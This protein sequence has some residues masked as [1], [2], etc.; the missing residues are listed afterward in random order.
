MQKDGETQMTNLTIA[1]R[2]FADA[3]KNY[4]YHIDSMYSSI[5]RCTQNYIQEKKRQRRKTAL[6]AVLF[7]FQIITYI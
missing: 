3:P 1:L 7:F 4:A 2:N 5:I 6:V